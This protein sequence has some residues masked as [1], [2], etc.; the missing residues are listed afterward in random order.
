[1]ADY[2]VAVV[3]HVD[4]LKPELTHKYLC[5]KHYAEEKQRTQRFEYN[6][7]ESIPDDFEDTVPY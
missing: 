5:S 1:M 4:P 2:K 7:V 3:S 6:I